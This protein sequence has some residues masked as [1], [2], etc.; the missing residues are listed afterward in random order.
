MMLAMPLDPITPL[1][2]GLTIIL[3]V[4]KVG[5]HAAIRLGQPAVLGELIVGMLLGNLHLLGITELAFMKQNP[6]LSALAN[7]GVILLLFS[8]GL[9]STLAEMMG[10]GASSLL[11][12]VLGVIAPFALG[13]GVSYLFLPQHSLYTHLFVG[14]TLCATSV[15]ITARVLADL[16]KS[17]TKEA[18]VILGAAVIDDVLGLMILMVVGGLVTAADQGKGF[19]FGSIAV[20]VGN[21]IIFLF[22]SI[23]LGRIF[24]KKVFRA[25]ARLEGVEVLLGFS[26]AL[27]MIFALFASR[28]G[29][30]PIV[31]AFAAGIVLAEIRF[32]EL[33]EQQTRELEDLVAPILAFLSPV[34]FVMVGFQVKFE[35]FADPQTR[36][37]ALLLTVAAIVGKQACALGVLDREIRRFPVGL[38]MIPRGEVGLIFANIGLTLHIRGEP[39]IDAAMFSAIVIMVSV[40]TLVSPPLLKLGF[41]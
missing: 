26:L 29:L 7:L 30:A 20:S 23:I 21:S 27:C 8:E 17:G 3:V 5:G 37:L 31:G 19:S 32:K 4:A 18:R 35:S 24:T 22:G 41:K 11:V 1:L 16:G 40:T 6:T 10:V 38:G 39:V 28:V 15:G 36:L 33:H 9:K 12:A 2:L 14:A 34:F 25:A 13:S